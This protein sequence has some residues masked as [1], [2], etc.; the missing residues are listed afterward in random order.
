M[1]LHAST[2]LCASRCQRVSL[3]QLFALGGFSEAEAKVQRSNPVSH[4][5]DPASFLWW[6]GYSWD[7]WAESV[8]IACL[9][10][11]EGRSGF[12][13]EINDGFGC[14]RD[15]WSCSP[16]NGN[17]SAIPWNAAVKCSLQLWVSRKLRE[18]F[19]M[20]HV[21]QMRRK[22]NL[23]EMSN[24]TWREGGIIFY[25]LLLLF[26]QRNQQTSWRF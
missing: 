10:P 9:W 21:M 13:P 4:C 24:A 14:N 22:R 8:L 12:S 16:K 2:P 11:K 19:R 25:S 15:R 7:D 5:S 3:Q 6:P 26:L 18:L 1:W 20:K 23:K 17:I